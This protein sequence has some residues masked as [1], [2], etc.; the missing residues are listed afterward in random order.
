MKLHH[1]GVVTTDVPATLDALGLPHDSVVEVV[2]DPNQQNR[3]HFI[4][5]PEN[6]MWLELVEPMSNRSSVWNYARK[7][8]V[9]L[10]HL[11][12]AGNDLPSLRASMQAR[13]GMFPLGSYVID[14]R[15]FGGSLRTLFVGFKGLIIEYV[16][17]L[18]K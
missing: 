17:A 11:A 18:K 14:V 15:S 9:G 10:H 3:L 8:K 16:E 4:A 7:H 12:F 6:D 2:E 13:P 1:L 5:L